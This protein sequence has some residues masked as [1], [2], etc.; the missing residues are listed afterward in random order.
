MSAPTVLTVDDS[1][2]IRR[3]ISATLSSIGFDVVQ[4]EDG[5]QGLLIAEQRKFSAIVSDVNM[6]VMGGMEFVTNVRQLDQHRYTPILML[7]TEFEDSRKQ[8]GKAA[9]AS[10]WII[11]PF[12]PDQLIK[13]MRRLLG[14]LP[15]SLAHST[16]RK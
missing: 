1:T 16:T 3:L 10:G 8:E 13:A 6:P 2:S 14:E 7:T 12:D 5:K 9:G 11:K 15:E 4:A